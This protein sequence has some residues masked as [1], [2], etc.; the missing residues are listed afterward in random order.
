M[1]VLLF[2]SVISLIQK[3]LYNASLPVLLFPQSLFLQ[4]LL[5]LFYLP[6]YIPYTVAIRSVP[7][8]DQVYPATVTSVSENVAEVALVILSAPELVDVTISCPLALTLN[9]YT[10][11][12]VKGTLEFITVD[13]KRAT[14]LLLLI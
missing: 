14:L 5:I 3:L 10:S 9:P 2:P 4:Y 1:L 12:E 13:G 6:F 8:S 11:G 7:E